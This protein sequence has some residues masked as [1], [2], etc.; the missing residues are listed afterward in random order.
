MLKY[1]INYNYMS[2]SICTYKQFTIYANYKC[3][4]SSLL[5]LNAKGDSKHR[6]PKFM[7][8][9]IMLYKT[10]INRNISLFLNF[11]D[12]LNKG[13]ILYKKYISK[14]YNT[15]EINYFSD[16]KND[17]V[18]K[19]KIFLDKFPEFFKIA[20]IDPHIKLQKKLVK[21]KRINYFFDID[22]KKDMFNF[23][24]LIGKNIERK[25]KTCD[26]KKKILKNF[27]EKNRKYKN[28]IETIYKD[29]ILFL[30]KNI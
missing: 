23:Q 11:F 10:V 7:I 17:V 20:N 21:K 18:C 28:L 15:N 1:N 27:L 22:D 12:T 3:G 14:V 29:D 4:T 30:N 19:Y 25:N 26:N 16:D 24:K 9:S 5:L 13:K 6:F 2:R 8:K